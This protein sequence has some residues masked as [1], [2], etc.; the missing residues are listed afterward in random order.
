MWFL[1]WV[2]FSDRPECKVLGGIRVLQI[3]GSEGTTQVVDLPKGHVYRVTYNA[4][5]GN[6]FLASF[7]NVGVEKFGV[8][9]SVYFYNQVGFSMDPD[10]L[11]VSVTIPQIYVINFYCVQ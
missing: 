5:Q 10:T 2:L 6:M 1:L 11:V 8:P 9:S 4:D 7:T 3:R